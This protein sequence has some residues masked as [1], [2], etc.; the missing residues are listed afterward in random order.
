[1][2]PVYGY[3]SVNVESQQRDPASLLNWMRHLIAVRKGHR[4]FGRGGLRF[5]HPGNRKV[6]AYLRESEDEVILCVANLGRGAQPVELDLS[7]YA[8]RVPVELLGKTPF[9][10]IGELPYLLTLA[11]YGFCWLSLTE[12]AEPPLWH[13]DRLPQHELPVLVLPEGWETLT[14]KPRRQAPAERAVRMLEQEI[15]PADLP[16][17]R[18]FGARD[19]AI[20]AVALGERRVWR[21]WLLCTVDVRFETT[22]SR[23]YFLPLAVSWEDEGD[24]AAPR[25]P[26]LSRIRRQ[27]RTG[28]LFDAF[29]DER[30]VRA[31]VQAMAGGEDVAFDN[32]RLRFTKTSILSEIM[33]TEAAA[34]HVDRPGS[35][36]SNTTL[37][38]DDRLFLKGYR[39]LNVG[40]NPEIAMAR[41]LT[42]VAEFPHVA[43]LAGTLEFLASDGATVPL[44]LLQ[45]FLP[46]QGDAWRYTL[47]HLER[48]LP[49]YG[50]SAP[51]VD[52]E[53]VH[54]GYLTLVAMLGRRLAE[55]HAAL[56]RP[57]GGPAFDPE[58]VSAE[59]LLGWR[60]RVEEEAGMTLDQLSAGK[61]RLA[62]AEQPLA[63]AL[64]D[65][66]QELFGHIRRLLPERFDGLK[67]RY[68]GDLHLGQVLIA[69]NDVLFI[70]FE[71]EPARPP[72]E[73][74]AKHS[75][76]RD[77]AGMLRSLDYAA[78]TALEEAVADRPQDRESLLPRVEEWRRRC[79]Q[80]FLSAYGQMAA[81]QP[82]HP[83]AEVGADALLRLFVIEKALYELRYELNNRPELVRI[84]LEGLRRLLDGPPSDLEAFPRRT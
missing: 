55:L 50:P 16:T 80:Q 47:D 3:P 58:P 25:G 29:D 11:G 45:G 31:L 5:L 6:L 63:E 22:G 10:R 52:S 40:E 84:P 62:A 14:P 68:H 41:F 44:A 21:D 48:T 4:V 12:D 26:A 24:T 60:R 57:G 18:W 75:P 2:D 81:E 67:C 59:E 23:R 34:P 7:E 38:I 15:L 65:H 20:A 78:Q 46:N 27:A 1:M 8:G 43:P 17:R 54:A 19:A 79:A 13:D 39:N 37:I 53:D 70:D 72:A 28:R 77:V 30:F 69:E 83:G 76:L 51:Q 66:R 73:R 49:Q 35:E 82:F 74:S 9:P 56:C 61:G 33:G 42:E 36:G 71:G 32:G 64:L